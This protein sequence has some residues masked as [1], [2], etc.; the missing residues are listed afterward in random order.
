[1]K[2]HNN[3]TYYIIISLLL[4]AAASSLF[5]STFLYQKYDYAIP[6]EWVDIIVKK[7]AAKKETVLTAYFFFNSFPKSAVL[8]M[9]IGGY[10]GILVDAKYLKIT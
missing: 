3:Y 4:W 10:L 2:V 6:M 8:T 1:M 9:V 7:C 5:I